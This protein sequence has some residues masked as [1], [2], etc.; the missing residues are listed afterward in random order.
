MTPELSMLFSERGTPGLGALVDMLP[1][2]VAPRGR[3]E[4]G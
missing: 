1:R 2:L 4:M 3:D